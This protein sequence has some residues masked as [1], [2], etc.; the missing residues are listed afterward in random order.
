MQTN[1]QRLLAYSLQS[2]WSIVVVWVALVGKGQVTIDWSSITLWGL[3]IYSLLVLV[4]SHSYFDVYRFISYTPII[5]DL[6]SGALVASGSARNFLLVL[7]GSWISS[8]ALGLM[9][10]FSMLSLSA[11]G[12]AAILGLALLLGLYASWKTTISVM[13][14]GFR[15][16]A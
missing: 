3:A 4:I 12:L 10:L 1:L 15:R 11:W 9:A 16:Q 7:F 5:S 13:L 6:R 14:D 8:F 2:L